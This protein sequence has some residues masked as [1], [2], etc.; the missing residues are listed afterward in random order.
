M[1]PELR[2]VRGGGTTAD[3]VAEV[4]VAQ[5]AVAG[6]FEFEQDAG[7]PQAEG[8]HVAVVEEIDGAE[9]LRRHV[10]QP[11]TDES[12]AIV[13]VHLQGAGMRLGKRPGV[14]VHTNPRRTP[15]PSLLPHGMPGVIQLEPSLVDHRLS[16][17]HLEPVA[18]LA[19]AA[20]ALGRLEGIYRQSYGDALRTGRAG[21]P[22]VEMAKTTPATH[23]QPF[24]LRRRHLGHDTVFH[25][26]FAAR[27]VTARLVLIGQMEVQRRH[28]GVL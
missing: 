18:P 4:D 14:F 7:H 21:G 8:A 19:R 10:D 24:Q 28:A 25:R 23:Q 1:W 5:T 20:L 17:D 9:R 26:R 13:V 6:V 2:L 3:A 12:L 15:A 11:D 27:K 16:R 22:K